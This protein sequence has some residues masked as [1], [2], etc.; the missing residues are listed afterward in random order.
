MYAYLAYGYNSYY[1]LTGHGGFVYVPSYSPVN[2]LR[3][4]D[5]D[6]A[7]YNTEFYYSGN[8]KVH[9]TKFYASTNYSNY[10]FSIVSD[11]DSV[12]LPL[13][14]FFGIILPAGT[15]FTWSVRRYNDFANVNEFVSDKRNSILR[16]NTTWSGSRYFY[17][18]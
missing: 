14:P 4:A 11:N 7:D 15:Q 9:V 1:A 2:L 10:E 6:S 16:F 5:N 3:P 12:R 17:L 8:G 18:K 13:L